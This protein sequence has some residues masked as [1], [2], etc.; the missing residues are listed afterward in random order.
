MERSNI[1]LQFTN[2]RHLRGPS[3][4]VLRALKRSEA[5]TCKDLTFIDQHAQEIN[6]GNLR[7]FIVYRSTNSVDQWLEP[8]GLTFIDRRLPKINDWNLQGFNVYRSTC[9]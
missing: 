2:S 8:T 3:P 6:D 1:P 9:I 4:R 5:G 7:G